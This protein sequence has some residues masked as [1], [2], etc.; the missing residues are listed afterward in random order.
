VDEAS[1]ITRRWGERVAAKG[2]KKQKPAGAATRL[3]Y[4][5]RHAKSGISTP[6]PDIETFPN[7]YKGYEIT[8]VIPEYTA[9]CPKT[10]LPDF[11]TIT[12]RYQ[13]DKYCLELK[14]LKMYIH[15]YRNVGI[16]YENAVNRILQDIVRACRPTKATVTGE[17][18]ARGGLR[19]VIEAN[20]PA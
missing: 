12:L 10:N 18:A 14:A 16:F 7:Q 15:A 20:Y 2:N 13:P 17:F 3:G 6:L 1:L 8:I 19:S 9:I 11:G 4:N 5:E